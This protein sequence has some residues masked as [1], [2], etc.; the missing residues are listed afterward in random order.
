MHFG[1]PDAIA[2]KILLPDVFPSEE[3]CWVVQNASEKEPM[4]PEATAEFVLNW[5]LERAI[6][7]QRTSR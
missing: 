5:W 6:K 3:A 4:L 7:E 2:T 1:Q